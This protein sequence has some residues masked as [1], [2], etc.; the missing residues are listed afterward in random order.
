MIWLQFLALCLKEQVSYDCLVV[1]YH[2]DASIR[3]GEGT[4]GKKII[5]DLVYPVAV[6]CICFPIDGLNIHIPRLST[7]EICIVVCL[8]P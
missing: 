4:E 1:G 2:Q 8:I 5:E 3:K 7:F 6:E